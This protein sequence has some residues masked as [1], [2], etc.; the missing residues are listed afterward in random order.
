MTSSFPFACVALAALSLLAV[1]S[2]AAASVTYPEELRKYLELDAVVGPAPGCRVCHQDDVGGLKTA[3]KPVGRALISAGASG[4]NV[5]SFLAALEALDSEHTDSDRDGSPDL[6]EL[7]AGTDP[8]VAM[9]SEGTIIPM[10]EVPL[11]QTGCALVRSP[12][13]TPSTPWLL[14]LALFARRIGAGRARAAYRRAR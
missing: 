7:R 4:G 10:E 14:A 11:P 2:P 3:T 1:S 6:D 8:N 13:R 9:D 5:P 12:E